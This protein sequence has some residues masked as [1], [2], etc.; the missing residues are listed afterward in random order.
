MNFSNILRNRTTKNYILIAFA[1]L[2]LLTAYFVINKKVEHNTPTNEIS[3]ADC[4]HTKYATAPINSSKTLNDINDLHLLHARANG[5]QAPFATNDDFEAAKDSLIKNNALLLLE[6]NNIYQIKTLRHSHPYL[7]PVAVE[8]VHEIARRFHKKLEEKGMTKYKFYLTS[9][10]RT[11]ETQRRLSR[12][13]VN[14][15]NHTAHYYGTT[16]DIS[17]KDFFDA[18]TTE[19]VQNAKL[20]SLLTEVLVQMRK[21][22]KIL[23]VRERKQACFHI[24]VVACNPNIINE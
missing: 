12:S 21:E 17:Y 4:D 13:N 20:V 23:A 5:L 3:Y 24:T 8:M 11:E 18:E 7:V 22:C 2:L 1:F 10:L 19:T 14:A 9:L 6:N 15:T 16:I